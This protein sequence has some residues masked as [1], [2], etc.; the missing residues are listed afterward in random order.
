MLVGVSRYDSLTDR[1]R[2]AVRRLC[3][4]QFLN[5]GVLV[6]VINA[7][8]SDGQNYGCFDEQARCD[9]EPSDSLWIPSDSF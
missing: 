6:V 8:T 7:A 2:A 3:I 4:A 1:H 5:T 9:L